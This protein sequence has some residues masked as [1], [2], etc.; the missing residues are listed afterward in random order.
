[1]RS[2]SAMTQDLQTLERQLWST[3]P[4]AVKSM[5]DYGAGTGQRGS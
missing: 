4:Q 1:V 2:V 3:M 5:L